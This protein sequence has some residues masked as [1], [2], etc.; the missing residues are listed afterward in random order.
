MLLEDVVWFR[1]GHDNKAKIRH[2]DTCTLDLTP[3][4]KLIRNKNACLT[5]DQ[6]ESTGSRRVDGVKRNGNNAI[7]KCTLIRANVV[8]AI[9]HQHGSSV[10]SHEAGLAPGTAP[11]L[12]E[13]AEGAI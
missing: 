3:A 9:G 12:D 11:S 5:V 6:N 8:D 2:I 4:S 10:T 13:I 7:C 1:I